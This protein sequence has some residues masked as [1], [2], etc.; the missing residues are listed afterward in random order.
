MGGAYSTTCVPWTGTKQAGE[1]CQRVEDCAAGHL[2]RFGSCSRLCDSDAQCGGGKCLTVDPG[3]RAEAA[4]ATCY[5]TCDRANPSS[6][7]PGTYCAHFDERFA[8]SGDLCIKPMAPCFESDR[9]CDEPAGS[10]IC[11][12]DTDQV[13]C[14]KPTLVGGECN[15]LLQ[16]GCEGKP[17]TSCFETVLPTG[18]RTTACLPA[19]ATEIDNWC[20]KGADCRAGAGC[21]GHVCRKYCAV[22]TNCLAGGRCVSAERNEPSSPIRA[23]L[24]PCDPSTNLPCGANTKCMAGSIE[25]G[26]ATGCTLDPL[27]STCPTQNGRCDEPEGTGLCEQGYDEV[28]CR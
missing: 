2:C 8:A 21:I 1:A 7:R 16:C 27:T 9:V 13:D 24:G 20:V 4:I 11:A 10:G 17:G 3:S 12:A 23:C 14:C 28:D 6:C 15:L 18:V 22:D 25:G 5:Q 19:G 26:A